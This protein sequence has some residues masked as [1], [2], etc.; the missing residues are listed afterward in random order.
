[1][2]AG[3]GPQAGEVRALSGQCF[4]E[5][6]G[7]KRPLRLGDAVQV[8]DTVDVEAGAKLKLRMS[9]GS[10]IAIGSGGRLTIADYRVA[11]G[12]E[13]RDATLSLG[14]RLLHAVVP[15]LSDSPHFEVET[16]TG[17]GAVRSTDW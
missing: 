6:G 17:V 10:I 9:D 1:E 15:A 3:A 14:E 2:T 13:R 12:G 4:V 7:Q 5:T 16:A 11:A 8:G